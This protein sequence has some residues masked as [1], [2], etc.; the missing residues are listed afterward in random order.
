M[1]IQNN[2]IDKR[3]SQY[4]ET[5]NNDCIRYH[6]YLDTLNKTLGVDRFIIFKTS[7][8]L[9]PDF[10]SADKL[11]TLFNGVEENQE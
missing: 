11:I 4:F 1:Y 2:K 6:S 8:S 9:L 5:F 3:K 10:S 7:D